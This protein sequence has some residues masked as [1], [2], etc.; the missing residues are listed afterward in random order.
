MLESTSV[1]IPLGFCLFTS[2]ATTGLLLYKNS[3]FHHVFFQDTYFLGGLCDKG[4]PTGFYL[5]N[6]LLFFILFL[7]ITV[8][9]LGTM[10]KMDV[11]GSFD[12]FFL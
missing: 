8:A 4:F 3:E 7:E 5:N 9:Q 10:G 2:Q 6:F 1:I 12:C 11:F